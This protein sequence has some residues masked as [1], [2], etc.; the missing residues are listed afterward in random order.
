MGREAAKTHRVSWSGTKNTL[1]LAGGS[2]TT[3]NALTHWAGCFTYMVKCMACDC[4]LGKA[5]TKQ[6]S[7][8]K[9]RTQPLEAVQSK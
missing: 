6:N 4:W 2:C 8:K 1:R 9:Q 3:L 5:I 7:L